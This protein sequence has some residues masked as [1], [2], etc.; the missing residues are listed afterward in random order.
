MAITMPLTVDSTLFEVNDPSCAPTGFQDP[1]F[2]VSDAAQN[3]PNDLFTIDAG[4]EHI[5]KVF[6]NDFT[7]SGP[8]GVY[9]VKYK[10]VAQCQNWSI[11]DLTYTVNV[12][13]NCPISMI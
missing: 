10:A 5:V 9:H 11:D 3:L 12:I 6:S 4:S 2:E 1:I 7:A 13:N 8:D